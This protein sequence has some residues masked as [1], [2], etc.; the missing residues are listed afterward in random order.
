MAKSST[1][2]FIGCLY[3]ATA[4]VAFLLNVLYIAASIRHTFRSKPA[5]TNCL[6]HP[7][8]S[9]PSGAN[10]YR[11]EVLTLLAVYIII[12]SAVFI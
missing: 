5:I 6:I 9:V 4:V 11:D 3:W 1:G 7:N 12:P 10:V 8:C 2:D